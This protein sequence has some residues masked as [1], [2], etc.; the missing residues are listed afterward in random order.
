MQM[1]EL[2]LLHV[3]WQLV[4][5]VLVF[6]VMVSSAGITTSSSTLILTSSG[7]V[8]TE[9]QSIFL[10]AQNSDYLPAQ[11]ILIRSIV[12][13][14]SWHVPPTSTASATTSLAVSLCT[15]MQQYNKVSPSCSLLCSIFYLLCF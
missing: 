6:L 13:D 1:L 12:V 14:M 4:S 7:A 10:P 3:S 8:T 11:K 15:C 5:V 9:E 2:V